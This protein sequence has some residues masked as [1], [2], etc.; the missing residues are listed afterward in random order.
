M[1]QDWR[2]QMDP[3][4]SHNGVTMEPNRAKREPKW[5]QNGDKSGENRLKEESNTRPFQHRI[6]DDFLKK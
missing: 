4:W 5:S 6:L 2:Y 1:G 3:K